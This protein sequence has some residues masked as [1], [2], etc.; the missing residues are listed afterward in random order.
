MEYKTGALISPSDIRDYSVKAQPPMAMPTEWLE[1]RLPAIGKQKVNNC[2]NWAFDNAAEMV[3]GSVFSRSYL[4]G[5]RFLEHYQGSGMY[6]NEALEI[7]LKRGNVLYP[8]WPNEYEVMTAQ[9][10]TTAAQATL[11]PLAAQHK[12]EAYA[13]L[14]T[15]DEI[16]TARMA[17][18][19]VFVSVPVQSWRPNPQGVWR[20]REM[21]KG[22][23]MLAL[24]D[25]SDKYPADFRMANSWGKSWGKNGFCYIEA[26]DIF[27]NNNVWAIDFGSDEPKPRPSP[28]RRTLRN[29]M[30]GDDVKELQGRLIKLGLDLGKWGADGSFGSA[31]E[32]A[33]K[34]FQGRN[35][36]KAD[37]IVGP[38]TYAKLE[39]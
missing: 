6:P 18:L 37:G 5:D 19:G 26:S 3:L 31:T 15:P 16:K 25:W 34:L 13:R 2:V 7:A 17:S 12:I 22:N 30:K 33:V 14:T 35:G 39:E 4:Y 11:R 1:T 10:K 9:N 21:V 32:T 36:L 23:H 28:I 24:V 27:I 29:G 8:A 38:K 20:C